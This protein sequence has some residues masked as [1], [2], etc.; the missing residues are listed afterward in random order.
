MAWLCLLGVYTAALAINRS[1]SGPLLFAGMTLAWALTATPPWKRKPETLATAVAVALLLGT[2]FLLT[3]RGVITRLATSPGM[4]FRLKIFSDT[5]RLILGS[6][7]TGV[8]LGCFNPIFPM[9]RSLSVLQ[10]RVLHPESD[11]LW[12]M[13]ET[14]LPGLLAAA[15]L[16]G[17]LGGR[18]WRGLQHRPDR[19]MQLALCV[20]CLGMLA[21]SFVDV[22]GHRLGTVMPALLL[23]GL[24]AGAD[25]EG[26]PG[27][28][29]RGAGLVVLLLGAGGLA[30]PALRIPTPPPGGQQ[31]I[32]AQ[33]NGTDLRLALK[34][35]PLDWRLYVERAQIEG[36]RGQ[37]TA[38][39]EDFRRARF[40]E[41]DYAGL[42]FEEGIYWL[43]V[44]PR[45]AAEAWEEA[46]RRILP[47]RRSELYQ[48][49][50]ALAFAGHPEMHAA[51]WSLASPDSAMQ[52]VYFGW[53]APEEFRAQ[54]GEVLREDPALSL[55]TPEQL[56]RL[57]PIWMA[58]GDA[59]QLANLL[60]RHP[61]WLKAGYRTLAQYDA[62]NG[63]LPDAV[64]LMERYLPPP[65]V[66]PAP[67][68]S[69][70]EAVSRFAEDPGD[71][72]AGMALYEQAM[73]AGREGDALEA[74][75]AM[76][77][78]PGCPGYVHYLE[79]QLLVKE[80]KTA[81]AWKALAQCPQGN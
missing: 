19:A 26:K 13:A 80:Q 66:P 81:E 76:S 21:H 17:W 65:R 20:A 24:A 29:S 47:E 67:A 10:E 54:I 42:P 23:L 25:E 36:G 64:D 46:L 53:A 1:R 60:E 63:D 75:R 70:D 77:G 5:F 50:M 34:W 61:Q 14:G 30:A 37:W 48:N 40:L 72:P 51:L 32:E 79:G 41:P 52:L 57:F 38:A 49:M 71:L 3:G 18:A 31:L 33:A 69:H 15:G 74:L 6:P 9:Y 59:G 2:I 12:L 16:A 45:F 7:W 44:A 68:M 28:V 58:K 56:G 55:F 35:A 78:N 8:G 11:W 4:D 22:P 62:A 43:G 39:L 27:R 73:L